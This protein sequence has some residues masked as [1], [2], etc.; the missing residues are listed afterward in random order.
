MRHA[1]KRRGFM[2]P[3]TAIDCSKDSSPWKRPHTE[4]GLVSR[5]RQ[6]ESALRKMFAHAKISA[7]S[8]AS[9]EGNPNERSITADEEHI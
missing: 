7:Q 1:F 9:C 5:P 4:A 6:A 2:K 3:I 8:H